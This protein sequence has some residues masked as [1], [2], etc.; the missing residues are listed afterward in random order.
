MGLSGRPPEI[1]C[2][3][4]I[5]CENSPCWTTNQNVHTPCLAEYYDIHE[6]IEFLRSQVLVQVARLTADHIWHYE[7]F[8]LHIYTPTRRVEPEQPASPPY[9]WGSQYF[10]DAVADEWFVVDILRHVSRLLPNIAV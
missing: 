4:R 10:G 6:A 7:P 3:L 1:S 2:N 8:H 9:L 5:A